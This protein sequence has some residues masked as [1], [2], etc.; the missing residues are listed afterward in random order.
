MLKKVTWSLFSNLLVN[1]RHNR[2][3]GTFTLFPLNNSP[4]RVHYWVNTQWN[5]E[6][7]NEDARRRNP[8]GEIKWRA[9]WWGGMF[10]AG[11]LLRGA[12]SLLA[13]N[14]HL[15]REMVVLKLF[16]CTESPVIFIK[17]CPNCSR[18]RVEGGGR[19]IDGEN[20]FSGKLA[21]WLAYGNISHVDLNKS[22]APYPPLCMLMKAS[23]VLGGRYYQARTL[24]HFCVYTVTPPPDVP[25]CRRLRGT[26]ERLTANHTRTQTHKHPGPPLGGALQ[27]TCYERRPHGLSSNCVLFLPRGEWSIA[28]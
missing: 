1:H 27:L 28:E 7:M 6:E 19:A 17:M 3:S 2:V 22:P 25:H 20:E 15:P 9:R 8:R 10:M 26:C 16:P 18:R 4:G 24:L 21:R 14:E 5:T 11:T 23:Y 12:S 13:H